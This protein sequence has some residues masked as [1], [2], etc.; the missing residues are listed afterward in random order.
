[1]SA[2]S[3]PQSTPD[4]NDQPT[5]PPKQKRKIPKS[6]SP[7]SSANNCPSKKTKSSP[8]TASMTPD[9][10]EALID[11]MMRLAASAIDRDQLATEVKTFHDSQAKV[12]VVANFQLGITKKQIH[13]ATC[14]G[15]VNLRSK[16]VKAARQ[17]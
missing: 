13:N 11:H 1:M 16:L 5:T 2:K 10:K 4:L 3:E 9:I 6:S 7:A 12:S 15:R 8:A 14:S 17:F